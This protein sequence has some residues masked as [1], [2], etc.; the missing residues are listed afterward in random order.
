MLSRVRV[1][2]SSFL[3]SDI[4]FMTPKLN[5]TNLYY[6]ILV[7]GHVIMPQIQSENGISLRYS[8]TSNPQTVQLCKH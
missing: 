1:P 2:L 8:C 4:A 7:T 5:L 3:Q 6:Q